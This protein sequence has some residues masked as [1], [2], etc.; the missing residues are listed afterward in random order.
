MEQ[1]HLK[2]K[3]IVWEVTKT[4]NNNCWYCGSKSRTNF[5]ETISEDK[6][7]VIANRICEYPPEE[8]TI[9]GGDPLLL[10][11]VTHENIVS[12]FKE[13]KI[14]TKIVV[15]PKSNIK[16][17][18]DILS[19]YDVVGVSINDKDDLEKFKDSINYSFTIIT[20]FNI[21]NLY[22]FDI[23]KEYVKKNDL[24]W[25]IQYTVFKEEDNPLAIY[26]DEDAFLEF[27]KK[28]CE[29]I[30]EGLKII[31][32]DN[33]SFNSCFA[34]KN[35]LGITADGNVL[36]CL[37]MVSWEDES[38]L[39]EGNILEEDL[40][41]IWKTKFEKYRF[42]D[43]KCCKDHCKRK[44]IVKYEIKIEDIKKDI[45]SNPW[46]YKRDPIIVYYGVYNEPVVT[47]YMVSNPF[48]KDIPPCS[49]YGVFDF[50][51]TDIKYESTTTSSIFEEF[52][53]WVKN[54]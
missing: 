25:Q 36:P 2:L 38:N 14:V 48:D 18:L 1:N 30:Q 6:I 37:S 9:S 11:K 10:S 34:G 39:V 7:N 45:L 35:I 46:E 47:M 53:E 29:S 27:D 51:K 50:P 19:L 52:D 17:K 31:V 8:I 20:N 54:E 21:K 42:N 23:I 22:S 40:R 26:N 5:K 13:K 41:T 44:A 3:E 33:A 16:Q 43:Y 15:S 24:S 28:V 32:S 4:C 12:R 49:A